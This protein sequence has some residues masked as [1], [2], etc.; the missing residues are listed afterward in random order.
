MKLFDIFKKKKR[1]SNNFYLPLKECLNSCEN[2]LPTNDL[3]KEI[4]IIKAI[5]NKISNSVSTNQFNIYNKNS[6]VKEILI[7]QNS[8]IQ[9]IEHLIVYG[10]SNYNLEFRNNKYHFILNENGKNSLEIHDCDMNIKDLVNRLGNYLSNRLLL[11]E[12]Y[13][14]NF[15]KN[16][17][18]FGLLSFM[19]NDSQDSF[20][21]VENLEINESIRAKLSGLFN[22]FTVRAV[23]FD[24]KYI[25]IA[26]DF[27]KGG[28]LEIINKN[29]EEVCNCFNIPSIIMNDN[30]NS[31]YNNLHESYK[32]FYNECLF[33]YLD[34]ISESLTNSLYESLKI[35]GN[36]TIIYYNKKSYKLNDKKDILFNNLKIN[37]LIDLEIVEKKELRDILL[38]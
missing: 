24:V 11:T 36:D 31:T 15:I 12:I 33:F 17:N 2:I 4:P 28:L 22:R 14:L 3:L 32:R 10:Y 34:L 1:S 9:V 13:L 8:L 6:F 30:N 23:P 20:I 27:T 29:R 25:E 5:I 7:N 37:D 35:F 16:G 19:P 18:N 21:G 26:S 38:F